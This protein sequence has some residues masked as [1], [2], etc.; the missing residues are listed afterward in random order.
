TLSQ[1]GAKSA[2]RVMIHLHPPVLG[3]L[4][5]RA[6]R[7]S[8]GGDV[9]G[10]ISIQSEILLLRCSVGRPE[11][12]DPSLFQPLASAGEIEKPL[13][14]GNPKDVKG[15]RCRTLTEVA[16]LSSAFNLDRVYSLNFL[17]AAECSGRSVDDG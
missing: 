16:V 5:G 10:D 7:G 14:L 4:G 9:V 2:D 11:R 17:S 6:R 1:C 3:S 13:G 12:C 8:I 15:V